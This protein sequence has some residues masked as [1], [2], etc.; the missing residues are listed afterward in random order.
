[1]L[2]VIA[3]ESQLSITAALLESKCR[4]VL[5][6]HGEHQSELSL[7]GWTCRRRHSAHSRPLRV[8][9]VGNLITAELNG[10]FQEIKLFKPLKPAL[11]VSTLDQLF[12]GFKRSVLP[13]HPLEDGGIVSPFL[14][15]LDSLVDEGF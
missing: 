2:L 13:L 10:P 8:N 7:L 14:R 6:G 5:A 4:H 9:S 12:D 15:Q 11:N 3:K 1:M